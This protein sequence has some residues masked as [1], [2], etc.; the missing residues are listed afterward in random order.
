LQTVVC[1]TMHCENTVCE[2]KYIE[3][4]IHKLL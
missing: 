1:G 3:P 4:V 2:N